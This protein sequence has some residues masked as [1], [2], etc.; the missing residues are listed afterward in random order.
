MNSKRQRDKINQEPDQEEKVVTLAEKNHDR[1]VQLA[2]NGVISSKSIFEI[3]NTANNK[4][5]TSM[6]RKPEKQTGALAKSAKRL[7]IAITKILD[8]MVGMLDNLAQK[9]NEEKAML[10]DE[11]EPMLQTGSWD[12]LFA[13]QDSGVH[14]DG[15]VHSDKNLP[16]PIPDANVAFASDKKSGSDVP[17][18]NGASF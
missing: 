2:D 9:N 10:N 7:N 13:V 6:A 12:N 11:V 4:A 5:E 15:K 3:I 1:F 17:E 8:Q 18:Y 16:S 14:F